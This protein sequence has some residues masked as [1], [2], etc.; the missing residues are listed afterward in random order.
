MEM[1]W[2]TKLNLDTNSLKEIPDNFDKLVNLKVLTFNENGIKVLPQS[3]KV[4]KDKADKFSVVSNSIEVIPDFI[5]DFKLMDT[6]NEAIY[7]IFL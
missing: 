6:G 7:R 4:M 3:L 1:S 5:T 2:L